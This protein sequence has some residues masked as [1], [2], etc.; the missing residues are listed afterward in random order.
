MN[1][2]FELLK[3][4]IFS[5]AYFYLSEYNFIIFILINL[6]VRISNHVHL[7][8]N[9]TNFDPFVLLFNIIFLLSKVFI[10]Q[11]NIMIGSVNKT[12]IGNYVM[13][14]YNYFEGK[15]ISI[16]SYFKSKITGIIFG[17]EIVKNSN[18]RKLNNQSDINN[19]L[20]NL[21]K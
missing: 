19:F 16:K 7:E 5:N 10:L 6:I 3:L 8:F 11:L 4:I 1:Q 14:V 17:K 12:Y 2:S 15:Y 9:P 21:E 13:Y 20:N 18:I